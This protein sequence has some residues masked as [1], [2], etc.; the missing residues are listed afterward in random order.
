[1]ILKESHGQGTRFVT[2]LENPSARK[3]APYLLL[4]EAALQ[5]LPGGVAE[6]G[7]SADR[8]E[9]GL[10]GGHVQAAAGALLGRSAL[11][12]W[13]PEAGHAAAA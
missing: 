10:G 13:V 1:M 8:P 5:L 6:A 11:E 2:K 4:G 7:C 9:D 12:A 3:G